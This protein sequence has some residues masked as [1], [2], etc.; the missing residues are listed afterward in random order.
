MINLTILNVN[1]S[2]TKVVE[3]RKPFGFSQPHDVPDNSSL[4]YG[5][6]NVREMPEVETGRGINTVHKSLQQGG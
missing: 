4:S 6:M 2:K 1:L 5:D 3:I